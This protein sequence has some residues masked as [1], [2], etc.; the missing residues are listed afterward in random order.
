[1]L[2]AENAWAS[3]IKNVKKRIK[4][5]RSNNDSFDEPK[6]KLR[7]VSKC[8]FEN[9]W[10]EAQSQIETHCKRRLVAV[11]AEMGLPKLGFSMNWRDSLAPTITPKVP[12]KTWLEARWDE[13]REIVTGNTIS[14]EEAAEMIKR[15]VEANEK[16]WRKSVGKAKPSLEKKWK[17]AYAALEQANEDLL[18]KLPTPKAPEPLQSLSRLRKVLG[19][20]QTISAG[21][22][23]I[24]PSVEASD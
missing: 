9:E 19:R 5:R 1:M 16:R 4:K 23:S 10:K 18:R 15:L 14:D 24:A 6:A 17:R 11:A 2:D 7:E 13:M 21:N 8:L 3:G 22:L 12:K 20:L